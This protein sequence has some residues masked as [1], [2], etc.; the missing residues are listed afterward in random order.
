MQPEGRSSAAIGLN[1]RVEATTLTTATTYSG[2]DLIV[3]VIAHSPLILSDLAAAKRGV[4]LAGLSDR[5]D[6]VDL[7]ILDW[8]SAEGRR[9]GRKVALH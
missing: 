3:A 5:F 6:D 4:R 2:L 8:L 7:A 9:I 1:N